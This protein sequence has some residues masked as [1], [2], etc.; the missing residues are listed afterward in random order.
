MTENLHSNL[1]LH[2]L[3]TLRSKRI[4]LKKENDFHYREVFQHFRKE[5]NHHRLDQLVLF[6]SDI[7]RNGPV[8]TEKIHAHPQ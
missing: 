2:H 3:L 4:S 7:S 8:A 6:C 1:N 5:N